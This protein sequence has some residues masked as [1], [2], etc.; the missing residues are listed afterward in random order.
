MHYLHERFIVHR[1]LKTQNVLLHDDRAPLG[2]D[3]KLFAVP[4]HRLRASICDFGLSKQSDHLTLMT[5]TPGTP[6]WMAPEVIRNEAS[7]L[8]SDVYSF[9]VCLWEIVCRQSPWHGMEAAQVLFAVAAF[10]RRPPIPETCPPAFRTLIERC[11]HAAPAKRPTFHEVTDYLAEQQRMP[12]VTR[13]DTLAATHATWS[14]DIHEKLEEYKRQKEVRQCFL[15]ESRLTV[16]R[17]NILPCPSPTRVCCAHSV[18][19]YSARSPPL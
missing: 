14:K 2:Q 3:V 15:R 16:R 8:P 5:G 7:G 10:G 4:P 1:D 13:E 17:R 11:W 9:G 6:A 12:T 18:G 19:M